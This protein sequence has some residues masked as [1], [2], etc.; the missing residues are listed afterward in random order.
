M[1]ADTRG[2]RDLLAGGGGIIVPIGDTARLAEAIR[3][4]I[5]NPEKSRAIGAV[6]RRSM[7]PYSLP[8]VLS[9]HEELY[10]RALGVRFP[11]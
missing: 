6:G 5:D 9:L 2:I 8:I 1:G 11:I 4:L 10:Q 3:D 7:A